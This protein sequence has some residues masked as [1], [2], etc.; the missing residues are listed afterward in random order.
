VDTPGDPCVPGIE[1]I[2]FQYGPGPYNTRAMPFEMRLEMWRAITATVSVPG[3]G[4][5]EECCVGPL[6]NNLTVTM[7]TWL[8]GYSAWTQGPQAIGF[9][10]YL[11]HVGPPYYEAAGSSHRYAN[12]C[13]GQHAVSAGYSSFLG[14]YFFSPPDPC[15]LLAE[16]PTAFIDITR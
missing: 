4:T 2:P 8:M 9:P 1:M 5:P 11:G 10:A 13:G 3:T 16:V 12:R 15:H 7:M 14:R 6:E